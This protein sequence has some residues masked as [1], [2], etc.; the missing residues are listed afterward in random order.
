MGLLA[1]GGGA[2]VA[3]GVA[4]DTAASGVTAIGL[5][6]GGIGLLGDLAGAAKGTTF[7]GLCGYGQNG[8]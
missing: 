7:G 5:T 6:F 1:T 2:A 4:T 8:L 3:F